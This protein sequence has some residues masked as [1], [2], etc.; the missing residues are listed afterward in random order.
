MTESLSDEYDGPEGRCQWERE[1]EWVRVTQED[2]SAEDSIRATAVPEG[3]RGVKQLSKLSL[4][5]A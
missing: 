5:L 1:L 3:K 2:A 4:P